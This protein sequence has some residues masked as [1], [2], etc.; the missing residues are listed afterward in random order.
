[1][2]ATGLSGVFRDTVAV[3]AGGAVGWSGRGLQPRRVRWRLLTAAPQPRLFADMIG[4]Q[5]FDTG[6]R[7]IQRSRFAGAIGS[8]ARRARPTRKFVAGACPQAPKP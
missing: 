3:P 1:M 5:F 2:F 8:A 6:E 7:E 4:R